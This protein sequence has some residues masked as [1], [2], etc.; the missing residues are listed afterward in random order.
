[1]KVSQVWRFG[2]EFAFKNHSRIKQL[3]IQEFEISTEAIWPDLVQSLNADELASSRLV[4]VKLL[5]ELLV[6]KRHQNGR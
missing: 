5:E 3:R 2:R 6:K 1:M 4:A